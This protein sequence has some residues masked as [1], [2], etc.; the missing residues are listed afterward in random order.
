[1]SETPRSE[2]NPVTTSDIERELRAMTEPNSETTELWRGA[3]R[4][5]RRDQQ[6]GTRRIPGGRR[7]LVTSS[8]AAA[9][10]A[11]GM[12]ITAIVS[13]FAITDRATGRA[14]AASGVERGEVLALADSLDG[15]LHMDI[16]SPA[17]A[18]T[19]PAESLAGFGSA[20]DMQRL[21]LASD[22]REE[23]IRA[24][25]TPL[26]DSAQITPAPARVAGR[27]GRAGD[28]AADLESNAA[29][30]V[31]AVAETAVPP[32]VGSPMLERSADLSVRVDEVDAA[33]A[34]ASTLVDPA[35]G[36]YIVL[37]RITGT[38]N[39]RR[40][41]V[42]LRV[43]SS[44]FDRVVDELTALGDV[45]EIES[46]TTDL[47][48]EAEALRGELDLAVRTERDVL[49]RFDNLSSPLATSTFNARRQIS[50]ARRQVNSLQARLR[51]IESRAQW[52]TIRALIVALEPAPPPGKTFLGEL[53]GSASDG[54]A[55]LKS[56]TIWLTGALIA[57]LPIILLVGLV[58]WI[59][60]RLAARKLHRSA[61]EG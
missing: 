9:I 28:E 26:R 48:A 15:M 45:V 30:D 11:V 14:V 6:R 24:E 46:T 1:M 44:R 12:S 55:T 7:L 56:V 22:E 16:V 27:A 32:S 41:A 2:A 5:S 4:A 19:A 25:S 59:T 29:A 3:L 61:D 43:S 35:L 23:R 31:A 36:E 53:S 49:D 8:L 42:S 17:P 34:Q 51:A 33:A 37:S 47:S 58:T 54:V 60:A 39:S 57:S 52:S 18:A 38:G 20:G 13:Q 40:A 10:I 21:R 50:D